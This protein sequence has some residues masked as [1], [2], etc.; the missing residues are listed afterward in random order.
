ME[1]EFKTWAAYSILDGPRFNFEGYSV[2]EILTNALINNFDHRY[3]GIFH[4]F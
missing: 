4:I 2:C 3:A 1:C